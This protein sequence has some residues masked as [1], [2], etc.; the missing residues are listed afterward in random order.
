MYHGPFASRSFVNPARVLRGK[1]VI[2]VNY[3]L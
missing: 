3:V 1:P 2:D